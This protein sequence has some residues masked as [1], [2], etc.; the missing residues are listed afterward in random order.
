MLA[1]HSITSQS[2][3]GQLQ[4]VLAFLGGTCLGHI[5]HLDFLLCQC[6]QGMSCSSFSFRK[7]KELVNAVEKSQKPVVAII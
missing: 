5:L 7:L 3:D 1:T 2:R 4:G 6:L